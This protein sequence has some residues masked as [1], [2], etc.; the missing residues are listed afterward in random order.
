VQRCAWLQEWRGVH[1]LTHLYNAL[2]CY[3]N[4]TLPTGRRRKFPPAALE[5]APQL[6]HLHRILDAAVCAAYGWPESIL[7]DEQT[8]LKALLARN[9]QVDSS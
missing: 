5:F 1:T 4:P 6:D 2:H 7:D 3:R 9:R 8:V